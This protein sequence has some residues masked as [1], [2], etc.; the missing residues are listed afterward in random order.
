MPSAPDERVSARSPSRSSR[1]VCHEQHR[2]TSRRRER[3]GPLRDRVVFVGGSVRELLITDEAA[4]PERP[5]DDVDGIV[6]ISSRAEY[7]ELADELRALGFHEDT[8]EGAPICRWL[9]A[10]VRV[11]VMPDDGGILNFRNR[12]Y[13]AAATHAIDVIANGET[14]KIVSAP[15]FC[16]TKLDAF[17]D[18]GNGDFYH[19]DLEDIIA[20]VDGRRE[21][22]AEMTAA[23]ADVRDY[24]ASEIAG[25]L[26][27]PAFMEALPGHLPGDAASQARLPIVTRC[28]EALAARS[29]I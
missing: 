1:A 19:H 13:T 8:S 29:V 2:D 26:G 25:L 27:A 20:L 4:P 24:I 10:G 18:R 11:D 14:F 28:L 23:P 16:A 21:L 6:S 15:Y 9:V 5:T 7:Y 12:W 22:L 3:L 17:A